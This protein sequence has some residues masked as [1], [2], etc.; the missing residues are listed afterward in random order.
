MPPSS[1]SKFASAE[2][3]RKCFGQ[4]FRPEEKK[5]LEYVKHNTHPDIQDG[6]RNEDIGPERHL[7]LFRGLN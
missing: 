5:R 2:I 6:K 3:V 1:M 7:L 4:A